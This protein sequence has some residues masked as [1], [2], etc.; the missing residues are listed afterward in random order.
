MQ[1]A[2]DS[3]GLIHSR[4]GGRTAAASAATS[5]AQESAEELAIE[6]Q[7]ETFDLTR[8]ARQTEIAEDYVELIADLIDA[9]GE[10]RNVDIGRRL[11]VTH[12]TVNKTV[13]R[14]RRDGL[15]TS[16]PY[17]SIFLT[18]AGRKMAERSKRRHL[19]V[20]A[21]LRAIGVSEEQAR[22]DAEGIEHY[23]SD[24]TL[25]AF[26]RIAASRTQD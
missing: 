19:I 24:E 25:A 8:R 9:Q 17:R 1:K 2:K 6:R 18:D 13:A 20:V 11:G 12:A 26:D 16:K 14:L 15:V 3:V 23:V 5:E 4:A 7:A 10:A 21:F 22:V